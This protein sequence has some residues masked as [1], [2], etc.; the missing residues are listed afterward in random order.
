MKSLIFICLFVL[1][2]TAHAAISAPS[3]IFDSDGNRISAVA[4]ALK[5]AGVTTGK[6]KADTARNDYT[7]TNV[8]T[9]AWVQLIAAT[10]AAATTIE[11]F[12]S[13]GQTLELGVGGAGLEV[14]QFIIYPGGN[15]RVSLAIPAG[16]RIALKA[17]SATANVGEIDVNLYQ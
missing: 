2:F 6:I 4:G 16:S 13:S 14:R 1:F 5:V 7:S 8:T 3:Y 9:G 11:V 17:I 10:A 12:D 15:G